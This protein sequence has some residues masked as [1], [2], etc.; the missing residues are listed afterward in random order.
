MKVINVLDKQFYNDAHIQVLFN[1]QLLMLNKIAKKME[2]NTT[3]VVYC[4]NYMC[5]AS[6]SVARK[7]KAMG[8]EGFFCL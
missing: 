5:S 8:F 2:K 1:Y 4:S 3:L 6:I 7:L